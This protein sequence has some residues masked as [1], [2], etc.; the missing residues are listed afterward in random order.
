MFV[1]DGN[2]LKGSS[3]GFSWAD[4]SQNINKGTL[5]DNSESLL[6]TYSS[7]K[8]KNGNSTSNWIKANTT[9][10]NI[11]NYST[12]FVVSSS[13]G[14]IIFKNGSI[15]AN[16]S[17]GILTSGDRF[18]GAINPDGSATAVTEDK[19]TRFDLYVY[20]SVTIESNNGE[21]HFVITNTKEEKQYELPETG[22]FGSAPITIFGIVTV[23]TVLIFL[24]YG[25]EIKLRR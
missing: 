12:T 1:S 16:V 14:N 3:S 15:G 20:G 9:T 19:A 25:E 21:H 2:A 24:L 11:F 17:T 4:V 23:L 10:S 13:G 22:S 18:F 5:P 7:K 8:L 6:W